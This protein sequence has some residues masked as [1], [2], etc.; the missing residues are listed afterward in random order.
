M[1]VRSLTALLLNLSPAGR[2]YSN[3]GTATHDTALASVTPDTSRCRAL[4]VTASLLCAAL[5][6]PEVL[7]ATRLAL[8]NYEVETTEART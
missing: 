2:D 5:T 6:V 3:R 1:R 7:D 4:P 8:L